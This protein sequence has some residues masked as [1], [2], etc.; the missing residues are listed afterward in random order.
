MGVDSWGARRK[1]LNAAG[2]AGKTL[3]DEEIKHLKQKDDIAPDA[4][5][6][7]FEKVCSLSS[8]PSPLLFTF[9]LLVSRNLM[10]CAE[11]TLPMTLSSMAFSSST[12]NF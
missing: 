6:V 5:L 2:K 12:F 11:G 9:S 8:F 3:T 1:I 10:R 7:D 4:S